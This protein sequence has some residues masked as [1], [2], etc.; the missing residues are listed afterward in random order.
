MCV[1][2]DCKAGWRITYWGTSAKPCPITLFPTSISQSKEFLSPILSSFR[3]QNMS[4]SMLSASLP[5]SMLLPEKD[6]Y[7]V[8]P[9]W[10]MEM[11]AQSNQSKVSQTGS[12]VLL[13]AEPG[14][15]DGSCRSEMNLC[16]VTW[17]CRGARGGTAPWETRWGLG[18]GTNVEDASFGVLYSATSL[19][20]NTYIYKYG[21]KHMHISPQRATDIAP[22]LN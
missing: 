22:G 2:L 16:L 17:S 20:H 1:H 21:Y 8:F 7:W 13:D 3:A 9:F 10:N 14:A 15:E 5:A 4:L 6:R 18:L 19:H 11:K 12:E